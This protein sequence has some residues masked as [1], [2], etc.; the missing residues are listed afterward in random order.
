[1]GVQLQVCTLDDFPFLPIDGACDDGPQRGPSVVVC[2]QNDAGLAGM[3]SRCAAC[4]HKLACVH[5]QNQL[6]L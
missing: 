1:V 3:H 4:P 2:H 5:A 6:Q